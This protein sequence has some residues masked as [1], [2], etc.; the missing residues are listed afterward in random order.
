MLAVF[1]SA[2]SCV[3]A[4][5][6][7]SLYLSLLFE[8]RRTCPPEI[9][10]LTVAG[11]RFWA[12]ALAYVCVCV[13]LCVR[14]CVCGSCL[15]LLVHDGSLGARSPPPASWLP[16]L[17]ANHATLWNSKL[18]IILQWMRH[19]GNDRMALHRRVAPAFQCL[20]QGGAP[21]PQLFTFPRH[22]RSMMRGEG[23]SW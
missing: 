12:H 19:R 2:R 20:Q 9:A 16:E 23:W 15:C 3:R 7:V 6:R 22:H 11:A 4:Y 8:L 18:I 13:C 5:E 1:L 14:V 10:E 17:C 21:T